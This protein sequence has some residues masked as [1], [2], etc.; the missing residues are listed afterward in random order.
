MN[1]HCF[2]SKVVTL[3]VAWCLTGAAALAAGETLANLQTAYQGESNA[4]A[5]YAAFAVKA[6]AEGY[7]SVAALFR[8]TAHSEGIHAAKH[9]AALKKM[10]AVA[11]AEVAVPE[12]KSTRENLAVA[13]KGEIAESTA[14]YPDF[15][16]QAA[17]DNNGK[18]KLSFMGALA[19]ETEHAKLYQ[20][21]LNDL[22]GWKAAGKTFLV[23]EVC[24]YTV[25]DT[26]L[27]KCPICAAPRGKF[28]FF[29]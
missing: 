27:K 6:D 21:A 1:T 4:K 11:T 12:V 28:E 24:G 2:V 20:Q 16:K 13:L 17:A 15:I 25:L 26:G 23:C 3:V 22:D 29:K 7:Q 10:D 9:A 18:A 19:A 8:A 5:R 14:M